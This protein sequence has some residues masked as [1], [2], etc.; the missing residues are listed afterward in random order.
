MTDS[1]T[2]I[3]RLN[4][5]FLFGFARGGIR[6][7]ERAHSTEVTTPDSLQVLLF[8]MCLCLQVHVWGETR[9]S[10]PAEVTGQPW[11]VPSTSFGK[12]SLIGL[13]LTNYASLAQ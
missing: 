12:G 1:P 5:C 4:E 8:K 2:P 7:P 6:G 3:E 9:K 10:V 11:V 13:E